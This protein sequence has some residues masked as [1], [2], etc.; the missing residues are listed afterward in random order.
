M[1]GLKGCIV[2]GGPFTWTDP[3]SGRKPC[4][5]LFVISSDLKPYVNLK[6]PENPH[7]IFSQNKVKI[8]TTLFQNV[9]KNV[10]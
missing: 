9:L 4:M 3:V 10:R 7:M 6:S 1:T 5:D 2:E 8:F